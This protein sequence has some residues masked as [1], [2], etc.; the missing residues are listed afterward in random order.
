MPNRGRR[1]HNPVQQSHAQAKRRPARQRLHQ[2][3]RRRPVQK[4]FV[5]H[6]HVIRRYHKRQAIRHESHLANKRFIQNA[7]DGFPIVV[8]PVRLPP[9]LRFLSRSEFAHARSLVPATPTRK[10]QSGRPILRL[11][12]LLDRLGHQV[13]VTSWVTSR[14]AA[15]KSLFHFGLQVKPNLFR[16]NTCKSVSKQTTLSPFRI[17]TYVKMGEGVSPFFSAN[18]VASETL[19]ALG[20]P[21]SARVLQTV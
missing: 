21:T 6:A 20:L 13:Y 14:S 3:A 5:A 18:F 16:I 15:E 11:S 7:V 2:P 9:H 17:N 8:R 4:Q 10:R 1:E 12:I 19:I